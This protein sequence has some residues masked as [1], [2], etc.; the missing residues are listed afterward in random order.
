MRGSI[1]TIVAV[2]IGAAMTPAVLD[3]D[4][5]GDATGQTALDL[6][7]VL[8]PVVGL[9]FVIAVFGLLLAFFTDSG[10]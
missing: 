10:F 4:V 9:A 2:G 3:V 8:G 1:W 6:V 7:A 5:S